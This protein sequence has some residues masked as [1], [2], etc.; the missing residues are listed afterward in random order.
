M[1]SFY[2]W[3]TGDLCDFNIFWIKLEYDELKRV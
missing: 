1:K 2:M 3:N